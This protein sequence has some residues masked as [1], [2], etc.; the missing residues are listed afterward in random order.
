VRQVRRLRARVS[1][2]ADERKQRTDW[3]IAPGDGEVLRYGHGAEE[4]G[5]LVGA[6]DAGPRHAPRRLAL[7]LATAEADRAARR[8]V[9][10][11]Q[12]VEHGRL[13]GAVGPDEARH[14]PGLRFQRD[15]VRR[16]HTAERNAKVAHFK[17]G[18]VCGFE[19]E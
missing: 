19:I 16:P 12:H 2:E 7:D 11:A 1:R 14:L 18:T 5:R 4:L 15:L 13:P 3:R 6:G 17:A 8:A 10:A 9:E